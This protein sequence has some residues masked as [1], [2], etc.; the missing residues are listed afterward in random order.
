MVQRNILGS[1]VG[2]LLG[3]AAWGCSAS[4]SMAECSVGADC[5]S[6]ACQGGHCVA[7]TG[8]GSGSGGAAGAAGAAGSSSGGAAGAAGMGG[9]AGTAGSGGSGGGG[10]CSPNHDGVIERA[11]VPL[12]AGLNAKFMVAVNATFATAGQAQGDGSSNWDLSGS[13][14]G[15]HLALVELQALTGKWYE[16]KFPGATYASQ[17]SDSADLL[18]VF[19]ITDKALLLRGVVS[20]SNGAGYTELTYNP[21]VTVLDFPIS[22]NKSTKSV[23]NVSGLAQGVLSNYTEQYDQLV[24]AHGLLKTPFGE[25][26]VLRIAIK[27]TRTV[28]VLTTVVRSYAFASECF[29][30]VATITSKDNEPNVEFT[31]A[32]E[33]RRLAP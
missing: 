19:E 32:S 6:G 29:G 14:A 11:E 10:V 16:S 33:I 25:F 3:L 8:G 9:A 23:C 28:G 7:A 15:D 2:I 17:L 24:D 21:P 1:V 30:T 5:A 26:P 31:Q 27:L 13:L 22:E 20:P 12:M 4:D 18:G